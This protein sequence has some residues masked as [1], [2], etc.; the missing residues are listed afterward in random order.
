MSNTAI[1]CLVVLALFTGFMA[2]L[3]AGRSSPADDRRGHPHDTDQ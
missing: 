1:V 3:I 2:G